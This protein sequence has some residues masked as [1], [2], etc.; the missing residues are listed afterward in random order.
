[1]QQKECRNYAASGV[2]QTPNNDLAEK[3]DEAEL[4]YWLGAPYWGRGLVPEASEE[5]LRHAFEDLKLARVW[6]GYYDLKKELREPA[7]LKG[8]ESQNAETY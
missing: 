4:G 5:L 8:K 7:L 3:E 1:M 6:C 2:S